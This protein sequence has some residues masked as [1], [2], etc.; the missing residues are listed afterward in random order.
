MERNSD[1]SGAE[2]HAQ[3][4]KAER[5]DDAEEQ[6]DND[7]EPVVYGPSEQLASDSE[8]PEAGSSWTDELV[9][10]L[11]AKD[12][13]GETIGDDDSDDDEML[14]SDIAIPE[15]MGETSHEEDVVVTKRIIE[16]DSH[17]VQH[18]LN[19]ASD[20]SDKE[21]EALT[22]ATFLEKA[23]NKL[24]A[25]P[26]DII[27]ALDE[28]VVETAQDMNFST[29]AVEALLSGEPEA[30]PE[31]VTPDTSEFENIDNDEDEPDTTLSRAPTIASASATHGAGAPPPTRGT[32]TPLASGGGTGPNTPGYAAMAAGEPTSPN[33]VSTAAP[34]E[35]ATPHNR[36]ADMLL[37]GLVGWLLA[38]HHYLKKGRRQ[39]EAMAK[40]ELKPIEESLE[41]KVKDLHMEVATREEKIRQ[42]A[43]EQL[44]SSGEAARRRIFRA[45]EAQAQADM[46]RREQ[47]MLKP[48]AT[49]PMIATALGLTMSAPERTR[50]SEPAKLEEAA[51]FQTMY[52]EAAPLPVMRMPEAP[53]PAPQLRS[54]ETS[55]DLATP[56]LLQTAAKIELAGVSA[57]TLYE[58]GRLKEKDLQVVVQEYAR[59]SDRYQRILIDKLQPAVH[60]ETRERLDRPASAS[61]GPQLGGGSPGAGAVPLTFGTP[62][63]KPTLP[64]APDAALMAAENRMA[65]DQLEAKHHSNKSPLLA[66]AIVLVLLIALIAGLMG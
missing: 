45:A 21:A 9:E 44:Q 29:E 7:D 2:Y 31:T 40:E 65:Q 61:G 10:A 8:E 35:A 38:R 6:D 49:A 55:Q 13:T 54:G 47:A 26:E 12:E 18:E 17:E 14:V 58:Q 50:A 57:K 15:E 43:A 3:T 46:E 51:A 39:G 27:V 64:P 28:A 20:D 19:E 59:G 36:G 48:E 24:D 32:S 25:Q 4:E 63:A 34:A 22:V 33:F 42:L 30:E 11:S 23:G 1:G 66:I 53:Q 56:E 62:T 60:S 5:D 37:G 52:Q 16:A 41:K